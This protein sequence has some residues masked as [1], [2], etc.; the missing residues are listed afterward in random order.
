MR[1]P[2][3][4]AVACTLVACGSEPSDTVEMEDGAGGKYIL[5]SEGDG[6]VATVTTAEGTV[7]V[8]T[9]ENVEAD[10]P[11]G[12]TLYPGAKVLTVTNVDGTGHKG[13]LVVME[14]P[15]SPE[16]IATFYR[17]Q[18]EAAGIEVEM[19]MTVSEGRMLGGKG[20]D[21]R[22]FSLNTSRSKDVSS[23]QLMVGR[24]G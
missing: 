14:S 23:I 12:Y 1:F 9:G 16:D 3:V 2:I 20:T 5:D 24:G 19:D 4:F 8:Q 18:A 17:K 6:S 22:V 10:L 13:T 7:S 11:A 15:D 21:D